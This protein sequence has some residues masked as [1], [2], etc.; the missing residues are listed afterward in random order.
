MS[1]RQADVLTMVRG[2]GVG[3]SA[4]ATLEQELGE[5]VELPLRCVWSDARGGCS[6]D[7]RISRADVEQAWRRELDASGDCEGRFFHLI[8]DGGVWQAYGLESGTVRG[9]YCPAHNSQRAARSRATIC[10]AGDVVLEL[11]LP[12]AA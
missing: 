8:H 7:A 5:C 4:S 3:V 1:A 2:F 6:C 10:S 12:L 11:E 9:V